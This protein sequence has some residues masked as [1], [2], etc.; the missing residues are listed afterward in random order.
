MRKKNC[1]KVINVR[2]TFGCHATS[3]AYDDLP[4]SLSTF[5]APYFFV[6]MTRWF[7]VLSVI[8][9]TFNTIFPLFIA[10]HPTIRDANVKLNH[11]LFVVDEAFLP[12]VSSAEH[13]LVSL[14]IH[15]LKT[16]RSATASLGVVPSSS[17]APLFNRRPRRDQFSGRLNERASISSGSLRDRQTHYP[18][19]CNKFA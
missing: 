14:A 7:F 3:H 13:R 10:N 6:I 12:A 16:A 15:A 2:Y 19:S 5:L 11:I 1:L 8:L 17:A 9:S 18:S 4:H